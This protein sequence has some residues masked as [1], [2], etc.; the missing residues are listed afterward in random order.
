[1]ALDGPNIGTTSVTI[2]GAVPNIPGGQLAGTLGF[3][4]QW[5]TT[6]NGQSAGMGNMQGVPGENGQT[7]PDLPLSP[8]QVVD[9]TGR[10]PQTTI[11]IDGVDRQALSEWLQPGRQ[12]GPWVP[13]CNDCNT[14]VRD[15]IENSQPQM[16][17][18]R[19]WNPFE[20]P[21]TTEVLQANPGRQSVIL[22]DGSV[23]IVTPSPS[24]SGG[25]GGG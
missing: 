11:V 4:H 13:F 5:I 25:G 9:H 18:N 16:R 20:N 23:R 1:M 6:S 19:P 12:T 21:M 15:V 22:P 17:S 2:N 10:V 8:T 7:S 14:F 24:G 3:Q